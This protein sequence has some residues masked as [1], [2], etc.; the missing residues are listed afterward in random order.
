MMTPFMALP[1]SARSGIAK[2]L[3]SM[4]TGTFPESI[5]YGHFPPD[6]RCSR[7]PVHKKFIFLSSPCHWAKHVVSLQFV[8]R[9]G[10]NP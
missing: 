3:R 5:P 6:A 10:G 1:A 8:H 9:T 4:H 7:S 2:T